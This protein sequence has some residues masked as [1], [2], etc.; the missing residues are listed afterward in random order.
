MK[1]VDEA[2][3]ILESSID[4]GLADAQRGVHSAYSTFDRIMDAAEDYARAC[5][6][7]HA[8]QEDTTAGRKR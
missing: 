8:R 2:R 5:A 1:S 3:L 4:G 7:A 6:L